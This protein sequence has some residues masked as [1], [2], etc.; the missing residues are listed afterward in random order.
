MRKFLLTLGFTICTTVSFSQIFYGAGAICL[1]CYSSIE[2][3]AVSSKISGLDNSSQKIGFH[4]GYYHFK[5]VSETVTFRFGIS[6]DNLGATMDDPNNLLKNN[7][8]IFHSVNLPFSV[9]Y[10]HNNQFQGFGGGELGTNFFG[11]IPT[12]KGEGDSDTFDFHE[13]FNLIDASVFVGVGYI[14]GY[15][16]DINLKYNLGVTNISKIEDNNWKK[17]W[18]TLSIAYTFRE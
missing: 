15:N 17:N 8:L 7:R 11:K 3:G 4:F 5:Y 1:D 9:H 6:Y 16:I 10:T 2:V 14:L 13:N 12:L 18:F